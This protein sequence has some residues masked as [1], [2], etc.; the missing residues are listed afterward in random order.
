MLIASSKLF[1]LYIAKTGDNFSCANSSVNSTLSTSPIKIFVFSGTSIPA[2]A[3][4][5]WAF[6]PTILAFNAPF[7]IMVFLT[8]SVSSGFNK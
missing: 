1:A 5:V 2:K 7:I 8:F 3:A 4:I 6:W